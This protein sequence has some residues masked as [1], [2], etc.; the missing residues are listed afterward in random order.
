MQVSDAMTDSSHVGNDGYEPLASVNSASSDRLSFEPGPDFIRAKHRFEYD[1]YHEIL[2]SF[3]RGDEVLDFTKLLGS[4]YSSSENNSIYGEATQNLTPKEH[5]VHQDQD[6]SV[7]TSASV[8]P[9]DPVSKL[10]PHHYGT[11]DTLAPQHSNSTM[12]SNC[13]SSAS[14]M[15]TV[16][17][18]SSPPVKT[19]DKDSELTCRWPHD[20]ESS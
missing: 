11:S 2:R 19:T 15:R 9:E 3:T 13:S 20:R 16:T 8:L 6:K 4:D 14:T 10:L 17:A 1:A 7:L 18:A 12:R 5:A